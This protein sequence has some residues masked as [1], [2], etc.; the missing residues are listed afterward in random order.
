VA[1]LPGI[2]AEIVAHKREELVGLRAREGYLKERVG[3]CPPT[4]PFFPRLF[5]GERVA[6]IAE[7]KRRSPGAGPI[8]PG[9]HPATLAAAYE[10]AGASAL[11]VLT[12]RR[13]FGGSPADLT[14]AREATG[15]PVLRKD[16]VL[17]PLQVVEARM[18]GADAVLLIAR[19]LEDGLLRHLFEEA[20]ELGMD[21]LVEV[22]G[23]GELERALSLGAGIIGIN[24]R[25][26]STFTSDLG[27]TLRLMDGIPDD[28]ALVSES[29]IR[30]RYD[31]RQLGARGVDAVLVGEALLRADDPAAAAGRMAGTERVERRVPGPE[32]SPFCLTFKA[33]GLQRRADALLAD[34]LGASHLGVIASDGFG[35]SLD[36]ASAGKM[37]DGLRG[38]KVAVMVN[39]SV[40]EAATRAEAV[41]AD[42]LQLHGEEE[43]ESVAALARRGNW[44]I[45]KGARARSPDDISSAAREFG[46]AGSGMVIEGHISGIMGGGG[47][48]LDLDPKEVRARLPSGVLF[49]LAGGLKP[50]NLEVAVDCYSPDLVDVS[51]GIESTSGRKDA[52]L[53]RGFAGALQRIVQDSRGAGF[54]RGAGLRRHEAGRSGDR[55][56]VGGPGSEVG[57]GTKAD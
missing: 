5:A 41:G 11:S 9:L 39:E 33:C 55:V 12:D 44:E 22:H 34:R 1:G 48:R 14:A 30:G 23:E 25:D 10:S 8:R 43:A 24:N 4:R 6:L 31:I 17:D 37:L 35:R 54:G 20:T 28:V 16:F 2:L 49:V 40:D 38:R 50:D 51:S 29:G 13:F 42:V 53:M 32:A 52:C 47:A 15:L 7:C 18:M 46:R 26:L 36:P 56:L 3:S 27:T 21:V 57:T 45:W 19:V